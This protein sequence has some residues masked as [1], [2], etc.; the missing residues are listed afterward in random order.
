MS[1]RTGPVGLAETAHR[2]SGAAPANA[3]VVFTDA[4]SVAFWHAIALHRLDRAGLVTH[5]ADA[6]AQSDLEKGGGLGSSAIQAAQ[7][8]QS[9]RSARIR[10]KQRCRGWQSRAV[11]PERENAMIIQRFDLDTGLVRKIQGHSD[12]PLVDEA[13]DDLA[14]HLRYRADTLRLL[15]EADRTDDPKKWTSLRE[16]RATLQSELRYHVTE[17]SLGFERHDWTFQAFKSRGS[18][19]SLRIELRT[20]ECLE[21]ERPNGHDRG[22]PLV[23]AMLEFSGDGTLVVRMSRAELNTVGDASAAILEADILVDL[24]AAAWLKIGVPPQE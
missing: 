15:A 17:L 21:R 10:S 9:N 12:S 11:R 18:D 14:E 19:G 23:A 24:L 22:P 5:A 2:T 4:I 7:P 20:A 6:S 8:S 3:V 1:F 13:A 16:E